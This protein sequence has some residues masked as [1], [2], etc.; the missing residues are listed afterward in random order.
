MNCVAP[1]TGLTRLISSCDELVLPVIVFQ[2][3]TFITAL[4]H[5]VFPYAFVECGYIMRPDRR[6]SLPL[7]LPRGTLLAFAVVSYC[8]CR[9]DF[10]T[11]AIA[12]LHYLVDLHLLSLLY[13]YSHS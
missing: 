9:S 11:R 12:Q 4:H 13:V 10:G 2:M 1:G 6:I 5:L 3:S 8:M 7:P